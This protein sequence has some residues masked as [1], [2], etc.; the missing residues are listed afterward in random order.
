MRRLGW[1]RPGSAIDARTPARRWSL[2]AAGVVAVLFIGTVGVT[3]AIVTERQRAQQRDREAVTV[4]AAAMSDRPD[5][6]LPIV[7]GT[8][9]L[10]LAGLLGLLVWR[11]R[12]FDR[13]RADLAAR[14]VEDAARTE[15]LATVARRLSAAEY[16]DDVVAI[17]DRDVPG[18]VGADIADIGLVLD[19]DN[20]SMLGTDA[21]LDPDLAD[22]YRQVP[23]KLHLPTT[24]A[25]RTRSLVLVD[26]LADYQRDEP[27][28]L[29]DVRASGLRS[30]AAVPLLDATGRPIGV[31]GLAWL[32][33]TTLDSQAT[34]I[35]TVGELCAKTLE[36]ARAAD[37]RH[38]FIVA[39]QRR[40]LP[41]PPSVPGLRILARYRPAAAAVGM[42]GDWYQF[43]PQ[44]DGSLVVVIGDVVGHGVEAIAVMAQLQ[45][46]I[47]AALHTGVPLPKIFAHAHAARDVEAANATVQVVRVEPA[48]ERIG[49]VSAGHPY[50]LLRRPDG[51]VAALSEA[52]HPMLGI[53]AETPTDLATVDFP[54]GS[55]VLL[56]TDGLIERRNRP[57]TEGIQA[58][59][60]EFARLRPD[61]QAALDRLIAACRAADVEE[62]L[63]DDDIAVVLLIADRGRG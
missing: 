17:I 47:A 49:Y 2:P 43:L 20:L 6:A 52:Q 38:A 11:G 30:A 13:A 29:E 9:T 32:A 62:G 57:I 51:T 39:L 10:L 53:A 24:E 1:R 33:S 37:R 48:R 22:R 61:D 50:P 41:E 40:L 42:G 45:H 34:M 63:V 58:L 59:R 5:A 16:L 8:A 21:G 44:L 4:A 12:R 26:D 19:G 18:V 27:P 56:Y 54:P 46:I 15:R 7:I 23:L 35:R 25:V 36:R 28:L 55:M 31:L 14:L 3:I 60:E